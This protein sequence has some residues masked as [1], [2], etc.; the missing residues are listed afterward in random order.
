VVGGTGKPTRGE[1]MAGLPKRTKVVV[2]G[3]SGRIIG[4]ETTFKGKKGQEV[5]VDEHTTYFVPTGM[6]QKE[7]K[8]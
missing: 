2:A 4:P 6:I 1:I 3:V 5:R 8:D 7:K